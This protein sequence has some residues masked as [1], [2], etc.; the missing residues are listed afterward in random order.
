MRFSGGPRGWLIESMWRMW[1]ADGE[2]R[3]KRRRILERLATV[4]LMVVPVVLGA[5]WLT[6]QH[7]PAWYQPVVVDEAAIEQAKRETIGLADSISDQM[8]AGK[9]F[10]VVLQEGSVNAWLAALPF[11]WPGVRDAWPSTLSEPAVSF[12]DDGVRVG[13]LWSDRGWKA[14][15]SVHL[16]VRVS[17]DGR[18]LRFALKDV[19][20]GSLPVPHGLLSRLV[21]PL[22]DRARRGDDGGSVAGLLPAIGKAGSVGAFFDG[23]DVANRSVWFNGDRPFRFESISMVDGE[24]RLVIEPL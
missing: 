8:V 12:E 22:L 9:T 20:G 16:S 13:V 23:V 5:L 10:E 6:F 14:I 3:A 1:V 15:V 7:K 17:S 18:S 11:A 21:D 2:R 24:L 19:S 4:L